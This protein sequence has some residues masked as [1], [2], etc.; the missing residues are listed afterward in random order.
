MRTGKHGR[1]GKTDSKEKARRE[2]K[3]S[4]RKAIG[5][6]TEDTRMTFEGHM[7][8]QRFAKKEKGKQKQKKKLQNG[9]EE[10]IRERNHQERHREFQHRDYQR[11]DSH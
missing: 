5:T 7:I 11:R 8:W 6:W 2:G 4:T 10:N 3:H 1:K 9:G